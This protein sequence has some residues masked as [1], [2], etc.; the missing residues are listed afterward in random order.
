MKEIH[1]QIL[2]II[3]FGNLIAANYYLIDCLR[4]YSGK[5]FS[6]FIRSSKPSLKMLKN[7]YMNC[8]L[9]S[10]VAKKYFLYKVTVRI[11]VIGIILT[12]ILM[13]LQSL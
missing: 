9:T 6:E 11:G 3:A 10:S 1:F 4:A 2:G 7:E 12:M 13:S 8:N 5:P